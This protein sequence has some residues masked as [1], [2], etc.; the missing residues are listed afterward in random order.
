MLVCLNL[1]FIH[2]SSTHSF[3]YNLFG[4]AIENSA[5]RELNTKVIYISAQYTF[6]Y[7][8][9]V[10]QVCAQIINWLNTT[11]N[12]YVHSIPGELYTTFPT[13]VQVYYIHI[14]TV[15]LEVSDE[16]GVLINYSLVSDVNFTDKGHIVADHK[17]LMKIL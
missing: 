13:I 1:S 2:C 14:N 15:V 16:I 3:L 5:T 10:W 7:Q 4:P 6:I 17:V 11:G 8:T 12:E 9:D